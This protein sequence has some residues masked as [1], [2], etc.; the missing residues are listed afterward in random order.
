M[1]SISPSAY[2]AILI[3]VVLSFILDTRVSASLVTR[4]SSIAMPRRQSAPPMSAAAARR[5]QDRL[6]AQARRIAG[7]E[8]SNA[9]LLGR[10]S[11]LNIEADSM[12]LEAG[13]LKD[14]IKRLR[15]Q[16]PCQVDVSIFEID[17]HGNVPQHPPRLTARL[18]GVNGRTCNAEFRR[19]DEVVKISIKSPHL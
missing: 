14:E 13:H 10:N 15:S 11:Q 16:E 2:V 9:N 7:L 17:E 6:D 18:I 12:K 3:Q 1:F 4:Y 5:L 19:V 8:A